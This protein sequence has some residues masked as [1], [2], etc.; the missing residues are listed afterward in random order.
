MSEAARDVKAAASCWRERQDREGWSADDQA[1]FDA[2]LAESH[3]HKIAYLRVDAAWSRTE[4]LV[5]LRNPSPEKQA[6]QRTSFPT[7][8]KLA[9]ALIIAAAIGTAG[10]R[11]LLAPADRTFST[12]VGG[13]EIVNFA[14]GTRIELNTNTVLRTRMTTAERMVWLDKGEAFFEVKHDAAH[15]FVVMVGGRRVTDL[16]TE[17]RVLRDGGRTE[18]AV[19]QGRVRFEAPDA[20]APL[21]T[22]VL[23]QGDVATAT[24][25]SMLLIKKSQSALNNELGWRRGVLV[26]RYTPLAQAAA[27]FNRYN[28]T[29]IVVADDAA[30]KLKIYGTFRATHVEDFTALAQMVLGLHVKND[31]NQIVISR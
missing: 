30:A 3:A 27:E 8:A 19:V 4:R 16:G 2:W 23:T 11:A 14:D 5:A 13:H 17:F 6:A 18:V 31:G 9:A 20:Q 10:M 21:Q 22:A 29:K 25:G 28:E 1:T 26:F 12:P 24:A 7:F 15:P